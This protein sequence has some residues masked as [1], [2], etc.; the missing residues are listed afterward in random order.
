MSV[1]QRAVLGSEK[2]TTE[3]TGDDVVG[4][5]GEAGGWDGVAWRGL[6]GDAPTRESSGL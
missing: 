5:K 4:T 3:S 6:A 2:A 1:R